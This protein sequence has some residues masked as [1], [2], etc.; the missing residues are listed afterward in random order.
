MEKEEIFLMGALFEDVQMKKVF[1]DC[2]IFTDC[3]PK[4]SLNEINRSYEVEKYLPE[5]DLKNFVDKYF[6]LPEE[7]K[8]TLLN[9][10]DVTINEHLSN[11]W[12]DLTRE[13]TQSNS[14]LINLPYKYIIPGGRFREI[15]YWDSYF[16]MLGLEISGQIDMIESMVK[17]FAYLI[18]QIGFIPNGNRT[19]YKGR[20]QPPFFAC[21]VELLS[22]IKGEYVLIN[23]LPQ[24]IRE[25]GFW[26]K[27]DQKV[28]NN[29]L[30]ELPDNL[31]LNHYSDE[32]DTPRPESF[33]EDHELAASSG[34][35]KLMCRNL[36]AGAESGWDFS[37]RWFK[38]E[39]E[40]ITIHTVEILPVDLNCLLYNLEQII[41][42]GYQLSGDE[43]NSDIFN[44]LALK[45]K[46]A[47]QKYCWNATEGYYFDYDHILKEPKKSFTLAGCFPMFFNLCSHDQ[48]SLIVKVIIEKFIR[49]GGVVTTLINTG[50]QWDAPNGWAPLQWIVIKGLLNYG[51]SDLAKEI[52]ERWMTLNEKVFKNTG[53]M[54]EKYNV[55][56]LTLLA[57]GGEYPSQDGFGWTNGVYLKLQSLFR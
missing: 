10:V 14:S 53:K 15:Y 24:L 42:K 30:V 27:S 39:N 23:Y 37:S 26:M 51:Y 22:N 19:Y 12:N 2:K 28:A 33:R 54:M 52:A 16:T 45:R 56:D 50:Q 4:I 17:N 49:N 44:E 57:G 40:F 38:K 36:R 46:N 48:A 21:M 9:D 8:Q 47:I 1:T 32:F 3:S 55:E 43:K 6:I 20:S 5:F 35:P 7:Q 25:Y 11:L 18:D 34:D 31:L 41:A 29:R 13:P